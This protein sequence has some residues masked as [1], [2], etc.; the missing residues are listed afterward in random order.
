MKWNS[1]KNMFIQATVTLI[2]LFST[3]VTAVQPSHPSNAVFS[4]TVKTTFHNGNVP[5][6]TVTITPP[7]LVFGSQIIERELFATLQLPEE[8]V[9]TVVGEAQLP[10][11]S[12]FLEIPSGASPEIFIETVS[13][14]TT[15]LENLQLPSSILPVQPSLVKVE[16][17]TVS[18]CRDDV[19]YTTDMFLPSVIADVR[20]LG[21]LRGRNIAFLEISPVQYNPVSGQLRIMTHCDV[22]VNL[23]GS[24]LQMTAEKIDRYTSSSFENLFKTS[25]INY[26]DLQGT[27]TMGPRQEGY[28]II[29]DTAFYDAIQPLSDWKNALGFS[30]TVTKT[31]DLPGGPTKENIKA[32]IIDAY[33][34]W[35]VPPAYVLLVGDAAQIPSWTGIKTGTCTDLYYVTIDAGNYFADIII[36]R[37]PAST[38]EQVTAMVDKTVFYEQGV[39]IN[40]S[41]IK[42]AV[43]LAS[44]DNHLVSEGT[45]NYVVDTYLNPHN[46]TCDKLYSYYGATTAQVSAA[47]NDGRSLAIYS[48]H[49]STTGWAD[50]PPFSQANV[51]ALINEGMYPFVCSHACLTG[52]F[53]VSECFGETWLRAQNKGGLAFWGAS[54]YSYWDEDDILEKRMFKAWWEDNLE[55]IGG[56]TNMGLYYLYQYYSGGGMTQYYFEAYNVLGDSSVKVWRG[57]PTSV[58][59][60]PEIPEKPNG[61]SE[62]EIGIEYSFTTSTTDAQNDDVFYMISWEDSISDWLG[63][64]ASGETVEFNHTWNFVG[65]YNITV[66]AKDNSSEGLESDWSEAST[67]HILAI[68]RIE[69][70]AIMSGFGSIAAEIK[71]VGAGEA[72]NVSWSISLDGG[73]VLLGRQTT[74]TFSKILPGFSPKVQTSFLFG[75]GAVDVIV[76]ADEIEKTMTTFL[77]GPFVL[78]LR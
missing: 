55:T 9:S 12:R 59:T 62:G 57:T 65:E 75:F 50:G 76:T 64:Y 35:T 3:V 54:D 23:P 16:G 1:K 53:T 29:V 13:W 42:K 77:L 51:N 67:I 25:F 73:L 66:K 60:P 56:M 70:G 7:S 11:I 27:T 31:V 44:S 10:T 5:Y 2:L 43:F 28:L 39:F 52:Q 20:V 38:S 69:I 18:F 58:N 72:T 78:N 15:S 40:E 47:L 63:P 48:G 37:F 71:N 41:W 21:E 32:Y 8:G 36:S 34:N 22:R 24:N 30:V 14:E 68:P 33:E 19:Y 49:G 46:Y 45:H 17:A 74:G 26:G 4:D 61:P 6:I